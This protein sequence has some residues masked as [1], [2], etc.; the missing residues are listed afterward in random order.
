MPGTYTERIQVI[1]ETISKGMDKVPAYA[2]AYQKLG[3]GIRRWGDGIRFVDAA[4]G[5]VI[6]RQDALAL[7]SENAHKNYDGFFKSMK[8]SMPMFKLFT[9]T[10]FKMNTFG[11]KFGMTLRSLTHGAR[12]FRMELLSVM[13][14]GQALMRT[15]MG[16][17]QPAMEVFGIFDLFRILLQVMFIPVMELLFPI[18][19]QIVEWFINLSEDTKR[20]IGILVILGGILGFILMVIG[21][22]GLGLGGIISFISNVTEIIENLFGPTLGAAANLMLLAGGFGFV[23]KIIEWLEPIIGPIIDKIGIKLKELGIDGTA[24]LEKLGIKLEEGESLWDGLKRAVSNAITGI[25]EKLGF[26]GDEITEWK[27]KFTEMLD[28]IKLSFDDIVEALTGPDGLIDSLKELA[29]EI[30]DIMP[31]IKT[32]VGWLTNLI[33]K[34]NS[35]MEQINKWK[36]ALSSFSSWKAYGQAGAAAGT[37]LQPL[38]GAPSG[39]G[40]GAGDFI[41]RPG[42]A[43]IAFS[44]ADTL[45][46][47]KS[48][49]LGGDIIIN[50]TLNINVSNTDQ[51]QRMIADN[52]SRLVDDLRRI[53]KGAV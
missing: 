34:I 8:M 30:G 40:G 31:D 28:S 41:W 2:N 24:I 19:L 36:E 23:G 3:V 29:K 20:W 42:S 15:F 6:K 7:A 5:D 45:V 38:L 52:N 46:G 33:N 22:L 43:P 1:I 13:F 53:T 12:G 48:G 51:M 44:P 11:G 39:G 32:I 16:L 35:A 26:S 4:T 47:T 50:Q 18:I 37:P 21:M 27:D 9:E 49:G 14:F 10:Q 25:L 17:L